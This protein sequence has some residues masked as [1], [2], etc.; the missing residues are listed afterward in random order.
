MLQRFIIATLSIAICS[1]TL[2]ELDEGLERQPCATRDDC[3]DLNE[4][5]PN[6]DPCLEWTCNRQTRLCQVRGRDHD[7]DQVVDIACPG[8]ADCN[9]GSAN[10]YPGAP[11]ICD[12]LDNNCDARIDENLHR[13]TRTQRVARMSSSLHGG[14]ISIAHDP[15]SDDRLYA[16]VQSP[17]QARAA[18]TSW[19]RGDTATWT[20]LTVA[21]QGNLGTQEVTQGSVHVRDSRAYAVAAARSSNEPACT[22]LHTGPLS[23]ASLEVP[24]TRYASGLAQASGLYCPSAR[25][26]IFA[27][28]V[29]AH[30]PEQVLWLALR[31]RQFPQIRQCNDQ[32]RSNLLLTTTELNAAERIT[33]QAVGF[34]PFATVDVGSNRT[35]LAVAEDRGGTDTGVFFYILSGDKRVPIVTPLGLGLHSLKPRYIHLERGDLLDDGEAIEVALTMQEGCLRDAA[36]VV[37]RFRWEASKTSL[38]PRGNPHQIFASSLPNRPAL[39]GASTVWDGA[40]WFVAWNEGGARVQLRRVSPV[41]Q[42]LAIADEQTLFESNDLNGGYGPPHTFLD[43]EGRPL[44]VAQAGDTEPGLYETVIECVE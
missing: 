4:L 2:Q 19:N 13:A 7:D 9:D 24:G 14:P 6:A 44:V 15:E 17:T 32:F 34:E 39:Y 21:A 30:D 28:Q 27:P 10:V 16:L 37:Q 35:L 25:D 11:E 40:D 33:N 36:I 18:F 22:S 26:G 3:A 5:Y 31:E 43:S 12:G 41:A 38:K 20:D 1:C 29:V 42:V 8:G 23:N